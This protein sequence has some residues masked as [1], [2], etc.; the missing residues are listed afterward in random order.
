MS[1]VDQQSVPPYRELLLGCGRSRDKRVHVPGLPKRPWQALTTLDLNPSCGADL[2][3]DLNAIPRWHAWPANVRT[4]YRDSDSIVI[5][6]GQEI[7]HGVD[8]R[9]PNFKI[10][11][12]GIATVAHELLSDYWDEIHAYEVLEHLGQQGDASRFLAHFSEIWRLLKPNGYLCATVP[13]VFHKGLW[14]DPSH[15]R[16]I[17]EMSLVFLDQEQY[18]RQCDGPDPTPMSDFRQSCGY[19]ADFRLI[20]RHDNRTTFTF[21]LQAVK[22]SRWKGP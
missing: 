6:A 17:N 5:E 12:P 13:S 18:Q 15:R 22:P 10:K 1:E 21:I 8:L 11:R 2:Q 9:E 4:P 20:D 3:C 19:R 14:G 7:Q 16:V